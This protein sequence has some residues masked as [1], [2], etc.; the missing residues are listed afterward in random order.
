MRFRQGDADAVQFLHLALGACEFGARGAFPLG[1]F[2]VGKCG[3]HRL[4]NQRGS[5]LAWK[6]CK[7]SGSALACA[8]SRNADQPDARSSAHQ[9]PQSDQ[10]A[11]AQIRKAHDGGIARIQARQS[12]G[13]EMGT[14]KRRSAYRRL[15]GAPEE[16]PESAQNTKFL[17][18]AACERV[19]D[20]AGDG[21][22]ARSPLSRVYRNCRGRA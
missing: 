22:S 21:I 9:A 20:A 11:C 15:K 19:R 4:A 1:Q 17:R 18:A 16:R 8:V 3:V 10:I 12:D 13:L 7:T 2:D 6:R 14:A 5:G